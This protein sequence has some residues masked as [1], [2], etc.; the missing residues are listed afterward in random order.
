VLLIMFLGAVYLLVLPVAVCVTL[1]VSSFADHIIFCTTS[2]FTD[3]HK[4]FQKGKKKQCLRIRR[5]SR[6]VGSH[7]ASSSSHGGDNADERYAQPYPLA[8]LYQDYAALGANNAQ[9]L[10]DSIDAG[11]PSPLDRLFM[12]ADAAESVAATSSSSHQ[13]APP[14][15]PPVSSTNNTSTIIQQ[16]QEH[17]HPPPVASCSSGL[18]FGGG[19]HTNSNLDD[20]SAALL[21]SLLSASSQHHDRDRQLN[22]KWNHQHHQGAPGVAAPAQTS[23]ASSSSFSPIML[24]NHNHN[25]STTMMEQRQQQQQGESYSSN[26]NNNKA[27]DGIIRLEDIFP[28]PMP[29]NSW[30]TPEWSTASGHHP[31][32][33][34]FSNYNRNDAAYST[35]G[36]GFSSDDPIPFTR[37]HSQDFASFSDRGPYSVGAWYR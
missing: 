11:M 2:P 29:P 24:K 5:Q 16:Q 10:I 7:Q 23:Q 20:H 37:N 28:A 33:H 25:H 3:F 26:N 34:N 30:L 8:T 9:S 21:G 36:L 17:P 4:M 18:L 6:K 22:Y 27:S 13:A 35:L 32:T 19:K 14:A 15:P 12:Q 31:T 1:L